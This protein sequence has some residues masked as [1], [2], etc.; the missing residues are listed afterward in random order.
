LTLLGAIR[1]YN[2]VTGV[3]DVP[4]QTITLR[5]S[6]TD[7]ALIDRA[8]KSLEK[9]RTEFMIE[10]AKRAADDAILDRR[11]FFVD[12][13]QYDAFVRALDKAPTTSETL[14]KLRRRASPW[15]S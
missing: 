14:R 3:K 6:K 13:A 15:K 7:K 2:V 11:H 1:N 4:S 5:I 12:E 10:S 9:S 8:A